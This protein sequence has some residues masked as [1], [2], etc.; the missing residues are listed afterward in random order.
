MARPV[1]VADPRVLVGLVRQPRRPDG[2]AS[3]TLS[4]HGRRRAAAR[5]RRGARGRTAEA[6]TLAPLAVAAVRAPRRTSRRDAGGGSPSPRRKGGMRG[7]RRR[8]RRRAE[9]RAPRSAVATD[10]DGRGDR[11]RDFR[12]E[13]TGRWDRGMTKRHR[14]LAR[15]IARQRSPS[16]RSWRRRQSAGRGAKSRMARSPSRARRRCT[17]PASSGAR[18]PTSTR[19][20]RATTRPA[21]VGLVYE[22]LFRYDPLK[23]RYIPWLA[24][25]G[26]WQGTTYVVTLRRGVTWS[27]GRPLTASRR[28]VLVRDR[29]AR[30]APSSRRMWRTGLPARH[31]GRARHRAL[32]RSAAR[33]NYQQWDC[34]P[35]QR[36]RSSRS[37]SG[38]ATA[39]RRSRP[40]TTTT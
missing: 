29:Q 33:P 36:S 1:R 10:R 21:C 22:T 40:A 19:S 35:L 25:N 14:G 39:R 28:E 8:S 34:V 9:C 18:T 32:P 3:S 12:T 7:T 30:R 2:G 17:S 38:R 23:D 4:R 13:A 5:G 31:D 11:P 15:R 27:D 20:A 16:R 24:T 26:R 37:T 6:L